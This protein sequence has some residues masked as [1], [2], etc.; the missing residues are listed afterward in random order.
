M[1]SRSWL[2]ILSS[3]CIH[4][5]ADPF[6][7]P[8]AISHWVVNPGQTI[9]EPQQTQW[10]IGLGFELGLADS[11]ENTLSLV[12]GRGGNYWHWTHT[13]GLIKGDQTHFGI[14]THFHYNVFQTSD[15]H[16][17][18][19]PQFTLSARTG[20]QIEYYF[21]Y[22]LRYSD[23]FYPPLG[24]FTAFGGSSR[25]SDAG[26]N[27]NSIDGLAGIQ[28]LIGEKAAYSTGLEFSRQENE[29]TRRWVQSIRMVVD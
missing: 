27:V 25:F 7:P 12:A 10:M 18:L 13:I 22:K 8:T 14:G 11:E 5:A 28:F 3:A 2:F 1:I 24:V 29:L 21:G 15:N 16:T 9:E 20:D 6:I 26:E 4:L 19:G 17:R 23:N